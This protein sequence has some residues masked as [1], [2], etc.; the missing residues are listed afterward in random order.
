MNE[1]TQSDMLAEMRQ[2]GLVDADDEGAPQLTTLQTDEETPD[3]PPE[4]TEQLKMQPPTDDGNTWSGAQQLRPYLCRIPELNPTPGNPDKGKTHVGL[5]KGSLQRYGQVRAV[6]IDAEDGATIRAGHHLTRAAEELGWTHIAAIAAEFND[7]GEAISYLMADNQLAHVGNKEAV[8]MAQL[9]ILEEIGENNLQGT[10]W[11]ID[12]VETLR[13]EV[14]ATPLIAEVEPW[15]GAAAET[16]EE[17]NARAKALEGYEPHKEIPLYMTLPEHERYVEHMR[18]LKQ[19]WGSTA[20]W[21]SSSRPYRSA[22]TAQ[23]HLSRPRPFRS[24]PLR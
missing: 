24:R 1:P 2:L 15:G 6:L 16:A 3:D 10:G 19:A 9:T 5:L 14:G 20:A 13:A 12:S 21:P 4:Q 17:A 18:L 22:T 23:P 11:D 7:Q 8:K